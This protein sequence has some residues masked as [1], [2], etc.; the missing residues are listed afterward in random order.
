MVRTTAAVIWMIALSVASSLA[1]PRWDSSSLGRRSDRPVR[2]A[3]LRQREPVQP[4]DP[5]PD[6]PQPPVF[7]GPGG[8]PVNLPPNGHHRRLRRRDLER[9]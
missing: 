8:P 6:A 7:D 2:G 3:L 9:T 4:A 5:P 1:A